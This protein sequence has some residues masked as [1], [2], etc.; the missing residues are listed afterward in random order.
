MPIITVVY[1]ILSQRKQIEKK[2]PTSS[3]CLIYFDKYASAGR[4]LRGS[5]VDVIKIEIA[6]AARDYT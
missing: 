5:V 4:D 3:I 6:C 2:Q 1:T